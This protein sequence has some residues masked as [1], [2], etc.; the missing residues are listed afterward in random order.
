MKF[1][2]K[3]VFKRTSPGQ[4][5]VDVRFVFQVPV[6]DAIVQFVVILKQQKVNIFRELD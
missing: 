2:L 5:N 1:H 4:S 3:V 6:K